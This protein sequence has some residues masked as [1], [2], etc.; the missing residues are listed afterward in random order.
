ME[1]NTISETTKFNSLYKDVFTEVSNELKLKEHT[2]RFKKKQ[3]TYL[4][5]LDLFFHKTCSTEFEW[6]DKNTILTNGEMKAKDGISN[7]DFET[8]TKA[9]N[10]CI[11]KHDTGLTTPIVDFETEFNTFN[12][13][14]SKGISDCFKLVNETQRKECIKNTV[15]HSTTRLFEIYT[16]YEKIFEEMNNKITL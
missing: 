11:K 4:E 3:I 15:T 14:V 9:L 1:N 2:E 12:T 6:I 16:K 10:D 8:R 5:K 13:E 7:D